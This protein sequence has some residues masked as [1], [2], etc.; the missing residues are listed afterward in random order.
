MQGNQETQAGVILKVSVP[1]PT[2]DDPSL[3]YLGVQYEIVVECNT[4]MLTTYSNTN[5][6][7]RQLT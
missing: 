4:H 3:G 6:K 1:N 7:E 2:I 5:L